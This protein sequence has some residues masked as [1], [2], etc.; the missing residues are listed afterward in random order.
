MSEV[1]SPAEDSYFLSNILN[2]ELPK[3]LE[4][5]EGLKFFEMG[6]GSGINL[7]TALNLGV[8]KQNIFSVDI[9]PEAVKQC[10]KLGFNFVESDLFEK[11]KGKYDIIIFN[12][13]YLPL[14]KREPKS[15]RIVTTGGKKGS[16]IINE[17][18]K[19]AKK[20]LED[21]GGIFL[22]VSS[23]TKGIDFLDYKKKILGKKKLFF[24]EL[25]VWELRA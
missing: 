2:E 16:E 24:E 12:P 25:I 6:S 17:F 11:V 8:K 7:K 13:P 23:K 20:Y 3:L 5:N 18:L 21:E 4:K 19:Q 14:D 1:Y 10:K 22:L 15:S 9:N